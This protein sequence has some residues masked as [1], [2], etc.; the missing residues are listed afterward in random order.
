MNGNYFYEFKNSEENLNLP[1]PSRNN[2][3]F[4]NSNTSAY[5][6]S[7]GGVRLFYEGASGWIPGSYDTNVLNPQKLFYI[8]DKKDRFYSLKRFENYDSTTDT[9]ENNTPQ[10]CQYGPY[11]GQNF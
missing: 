5:Q 2:I 4:Y 10:F 1:K 9:W 3:G 6:S 7:T 8:T 11:D